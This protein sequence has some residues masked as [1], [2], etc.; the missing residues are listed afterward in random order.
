MGSKLQGLMAEH[1]S[2][3]FAHECSYNTVFK[4]CASSYIGSHDF[5]PFFYFIRSNTST[6]RCNFSLFLV[7]Y[8]KKSIICPPHDRSCVQRR[9]YP[10]FLLQRKLIQRLYKV[11]Y[12]KSRLTT[13]KKSALLHPYCP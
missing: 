2:S 12:G 10:Y 6:F 4:P 1:N 5:F 11:T 9:K 7:N 8:V 13:L 3:P